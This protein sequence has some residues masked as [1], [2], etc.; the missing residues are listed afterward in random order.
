MSQEEPGGVRRSQEEPALLR[1]LKPFPP[2]GHSSFALNNKRM[3]P[4]SCDDTAGAAVGG[5]ATR[6]SYRPREVP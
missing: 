4:A 5:V 3:S 1:A 2:R 6:S